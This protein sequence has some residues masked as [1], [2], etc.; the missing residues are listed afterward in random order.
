[1]YSHWDN[2]SVIE[3]EKAQA[4]LEG[5]YCSLRFSSGMAIIS[6][7]LLTVLKSG[8]RV[9]S[10][11]EIYGGTYEFFNDVLARRN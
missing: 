8:S 2:P 11:R 10:T 7:T 4:A 9:F 5:Y 3:V 1:M 6:T